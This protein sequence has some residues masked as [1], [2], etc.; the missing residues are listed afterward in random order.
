M[1]NVPSEDVL[2]DGSDYS[3]R[4]EL[5]ADTD[6]YRVT[7]MFSI[8]VGAV[9]YDTDEILEV[10]YWNVLAS[11]ILLLCAL[12]ALYWHQKILFSNYRLIMWVPIWLIEIAELFVIWLSASDYLNSSNEGSMTCSK[13]E[14]DIV[15]GAIILQLIQIFSVNVCCLYNLMEGTKYLE[16]FFLVLD[17]MECVILMILA[18]TCG[19]PEDILDVTLTCVC[20][21]FAVPFTLNS[22]F[23]RLRGMTL[24]EVPSEKYTAVLPNP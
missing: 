13:E 4:I 22:A 6:Q 14:A 5:S 10:S 12:C 8:G 3:I 11:G 23:T 15:W 19:Q 2:A 18:V 21:F 9:K 1:W 24:V 7:D 20:L 17:L 16:Y